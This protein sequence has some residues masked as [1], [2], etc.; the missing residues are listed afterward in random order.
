M[1]KRIF[2]IV[3]LVT[4][5]GAFSFPF[6]L[7]GQVAKA[8]SLNSQMQDAPIHPTVSAG[9]WIVFNGQSAPASPD[10]RVTASS[11]EAVELVAE[12]TGVQTEARMIGEVSYTA[13]TGNGFGEG[14]QVG[15][16]DLP[17]LRKYVEI[18]FGA[19][20]TL[21]IVRSQLAETSLS[22]L[23]LQNPVAP[24]QPPDCKCADP[25]ATAPV[26]PDAAVYQRDEYFP[27]SP[28]AIS[29][30]FIQRGHRVLV[31]EVWP[32]AYN[33]VTGGL[34][35]FSQVD[36]RIN[37]SGSN[38]ALTQVKA[39]RYA[40]PAFSSQMAR[41]ILNF[42]QGTA[43]VFSP[44][45]PVG[46]LII[47]A[48]AYYDAMLPFAALE[49]ARGFTVTLT[50]LS[51]IPATTKEQVKA[52]I[53]T[54]YDT[55]AVPPSYVLLAGDTDTIP[56][57]SSTQ[58]SGKYTDLYYFTM[59]GASDWHP[60]LGRGRFPVRTAAQATIM[61]NKYL[62]YY[63]F[64]GNEPWL[65][66]IAYIATCD[67]YT[68]AEATHNYVINTYT[69]PKGYTGMFPVNPQPGGDKIYCVTNSGNAQNIR[70]AANDGRW[71]II[72]SGHG[73]E[74]GWADGDVSFSQTDVR[75]LT[76]GGF[77][78]F[79]ASHACVTGSF[80]QTEAY[81]ETWVLQD[82]KGA[83][84][85][86]GASHN[87]YWDEDDVLEKAMFDSLF[88]EGDEHADVWTMT[89][90][91]LAQVEAD[92]PSSAQYYYEAYN[93]MGEG[94][95]KIFLE[96]EGPALELSANPGEMAVCSVDDVTTTVSAESVLAAGQT[97]SM[98][99]VGEP[100]GVNA[101]FAPAS[102][103]L[104]GDSELTLA[105][106]G[107]AAPGVYPIEVIGTTPEVS[108]TTQV[109]LSVFTAAAGL[110]TLLTPAD[111]T[112][113]QLLRPVF[114]WDSAQGGEYDLQVATDTDFTQ[115]VIDETGLK[116]ASFTPAADLQ[117]NTIYFWRVRA[118]NACGDSVFSEP[119]RFLTEPVI[120]QCVLGTTLTTLLS[121]DFETPL[122]GW[123]HSGLGDTWGLTSLRYH[124]GA[125]SFM[126]QNVQSVSDQQLTTP[127]VS[128]P[129][130]QSPL[131][132]EFWDYQR[133][134]N[135]A[136]GCYDGGILE[137][138]TDGGQTWTQLEDEL[139]T[140][141]YDGPIAS[142]SQNPLAG[143]NAWCGKPRSWSKTIVDLDAYAGQNAQ[144][145]FRLGTN[146]A[147]SYEGWYV[148]DV[149]VTA[150][151][152]TSSLG[153][154]S[155]TTGLPGESVLHTFT[156]TNQ[157][158]TDQFALSV[159]GNAWPTTIVGGDLVTVT[160]GA[161][162]T[163]TVQVDVPE[164]RAVTSDD[165]LLAASSQ[166][167][168]GIV[169]YAQGFTE[170]DAQPAVSLS[171]PQQRG[172]F[173]GELPTYVFTITNQGLM[174]DTFSLQVTGLW[175]AIILDGETTPPVAPGGS[176]TVTIVV[177]IP[178]TAVGG[179]FDVTT[180]IVT[181]GWD[182]EVTASVTATTT[183]WYRLYLPAV[184]R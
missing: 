131:T 106:N 108:A 127:G 60:D 99:A 113:N 117:P 39:D 178:M 55:W 73:S 83:L 149:A 147:V 11:A 124:S 16:P 160:L 79:V 165:F 130:G 184:Q 76:D 181:S 88:A 135:R 85:F 2:H 150:C 19:Q 158:E 47:T 3:A 12:I 14:A 65:K 104:P 102:F 43:R 54:A 46:Y 138:S 53:Q 51:Q 156:L 31:V 133:L 137:I 82:G 5:I 132:L 162:V 94:S 148:D 66:K 182:S 159:S 25:S 164:L 80:N 57:W 27:A 75:N 179:D 176:V 17:V 78:P 1:L 56:A 103:V 64:T 20:A 143:A 7:T 41:T 107:S 126:A 36:F 8:T 141:P 168:P 72:Y 13:I 169:L 68:V 42:D 24:L 183:A 128:L 71:A 139:L 86:W 153:Q 62:A 9:G 61:V 120:G 70:N 89:D 38:M 98:D 122:T 45:V 21:E 109:T 84:V 81:A 58:S 112:N 10:L 142:G 28:V 23:G 69:Q 101:T 95:V 22:Q 18:P 91:G 105:N 49:Q 172:A 97:V 33:P 121:T 115:L 146:N 116:T 118:H 134:E 170:L 167:I 50:K 161:S 119:S 110:P 174:T 163:V 114:S 166:T 125:S 171:D 154:D 37:L 177:E 87:T 4:L 151:T 144:F 175:G 129:A 157:G 145:R 123:S 35:F 77:Y 136:G 6:S 90:Y 26:G 180:L 40:S 111:N 67:N 44:N 152:P 32:V 59:D 29:G 15:M 140:N 155:Q 52:Y 173:P 93:I 74:T 92:Y 48:D 100:A 96:P 34:R 63:G 30:E